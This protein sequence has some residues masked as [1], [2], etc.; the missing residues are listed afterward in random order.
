MPR[1]RKA[2]CGGDGVRGRWTRDH[3]EF[4]GRLATGPGAALASG[5]S[6][7]TRASAAP[8]GTGGRQ[9][10]RKLARP[11]PS[12]GLAGAAAV[13]GPVAASARP[14]TLRATCGERRS[15]GFDLCVCFCH[16]PD[17]DP[18]ATR[19]PPRP[20]TN[21][22]D[23]MRGEANAT[24][25]GTRTH[26]QK[27]DHHRTARPRRRAGPST[28]TLATDTAT[29]SSPHRTIKTPQPAARAR[30]IRTLPQKIEIDVDRS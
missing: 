24:R 22:P 25:S 11:A 13:A 23:P 7:P 28:K 20:R 10:T 12:V 6:S 17:L 1:R 19:A 27:R 3:C 15:I 16:L 21:E 29:S 5:G 8:P 2:T 26:I 4:R 9:G 18:R 14:M 30:G